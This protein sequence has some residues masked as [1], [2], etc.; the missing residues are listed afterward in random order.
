MA[1]ATTMNLPCQL[2]DE[3]V[4][5]RAADLANI[6]VEVEHT[7]GRLKVK[8]SELRAEVKRGRQRAAELAKVVSTRSE[9]REVEVYEEPDPGAG[10]VWT[11]R[12]DTGQRVESRAM[13]ADDRQLELVPARVLPF[14]ARSGEA[15][16]ERASEHAQAQAVERAH[17]R[18][19]AEPPT[20]A[21]DHAPV[22]HDDNREAE[23]W[24]PC[25]ECDCQG[26]AGKAPG[27]VPEELVF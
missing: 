4:L 23:G 3:E 27:S 12:R 20:C 16:T 15:A 2:T 7:E 8:R 13:D 25:R 1:K 14:D 21:C 11:V 10:L 6:V 19:R 24:G 22:Q 18:T 9:Q 5:L 26:T 17:A